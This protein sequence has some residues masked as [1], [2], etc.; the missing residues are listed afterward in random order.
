MIITLGWAYPWWK[1]S[2]YRLKTNDMRF[3]DQPFRFEGSA[4]S[5][6]V[7]FAT[8]WIGVALIVAAAAMAEIY[9]PV[10]MC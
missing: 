1:T 2:L 4:A 5:L 8:V 6:Y 7:P 3:G 10:A 9:G